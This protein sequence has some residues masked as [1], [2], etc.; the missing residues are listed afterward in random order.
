MNPI[1]RNA[2]LVATLVSLPGCAGKRALMPEDRLSLS[3][4]PQIIA[5]HFPPEQDFYVKAPF[6]QAGMLGVVEASYETASLQRNAG[7]ED[8]AP[9]V[10]DRLVNALRANLNLTNVRTVSEWPQNMNVAFEALRETRRAGTALDVETNTRKFDSALKEAFGSGVV[11]EVQTRTWRVESTRVVYSA[12]ARMLRLSDSA[13]IWRVACTRVSQVQ[14]SDVPALA[15]KPAAN[16][17]QVP[18]QEELWMEQALKANDGALLRAK[19]REAAD[20]CADSLAEQALGRVNQP[21]R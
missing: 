7:L 18:R 21:K 10:K 13:D 4:Q 9:H 2:I 17:P 20:T 12:R 16:I 1:A 15:E 19:L 6:F 14:V 11:L 5:I 8:P 3:S